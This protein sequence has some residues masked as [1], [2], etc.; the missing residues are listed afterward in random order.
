MYARF[1]NLTIAKSHHRE[2]PPPRHLIG[3]GLPHTRPG[4][5]PYHQPHSLSHSPAT[6]SVQA[7]PAGTR[8]WQ[9]DKFVLLL[10]FLYYL[11]LGVLTSWFL[12]FVN[13]KVS[14]GSDGGTTKDS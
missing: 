1:E 8:V 14:V 11:L 4:I 12:S 2:S 5:L 10:S 3:P 6:R 13:K 9:L 7:H